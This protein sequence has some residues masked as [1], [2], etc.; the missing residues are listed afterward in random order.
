[1]A[2]KS[3]DLFAYQGTPVLC[4]SMDDTSAPDFVYQGGPFIL[5]EQ[6]AGASYVYDADGKLKQINFTNYEVV[7]I[8]YDNV[9]NR[10]SV[11]T[12]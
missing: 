10:T 3:F 6:S 7:T 5:P 8:N 2:S 11:V 9:G 4:G 12:T 1:M